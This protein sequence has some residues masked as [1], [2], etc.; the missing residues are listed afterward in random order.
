MWRSLLMLRFILPQTSFDAWWSCS[1]FL[2]SLRIRQHAPAIVRSL[3]LQHWE[4]V[5][6]EIWNFDA[7]WNDVDI[8]REKTSWT[9]IEDHIVL[10]FLSK[11]LPFGIVF[12]LS[13]ISGT[14]HGDTSSK[15]RCFVES[16]TS[17][18]TNRFACHDVPDFWWLLRPIL[19][20]LHNKNGW[21]LLGEEPKSTVVIKIVVFWLPQ[22]V[23]F[24]TQNLFIANKL[25]MFVAPNCF[26]P[27]NGCGFFWGL[28]IEAAKLTRKSQGVP[29]CQAAAA[30]RFAWSSTWASW[31]C[32][33]ETK[34]HVWIGLGGLGKKC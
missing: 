26:S 11:K 20:A 30:T 12:N 21:F 6:F 9:L 34:T 2:S 5:R 31:R 25:L 4:N 3:Y 22:L 28:S 23:V 7:V 18:A 1:I 8:L 32:R 17:F 15:N 16:T 29:A 24:A 27:A 19:K 14:K 13:G 10:V 33:W